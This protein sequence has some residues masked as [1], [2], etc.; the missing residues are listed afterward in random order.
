MNFPYLFRDMMPT[1]QDGARQ[2][3]KQEILA[4]ACPLQYIAQPGISKIPIWIAAQP[5]T[6][7]VQDE[8]RQI[9]HQI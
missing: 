4:E 7:F 6:K 5:Q 1:K 8:P 9:K 3:G 2:K